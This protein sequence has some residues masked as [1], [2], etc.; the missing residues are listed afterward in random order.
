[1]FDFAKELR[2]ATDDSR[3]ETNKHKTYFK[4]KSFCLRIAKDIGMSVAAVNKVLLMGV[5]DAESVRDQ[6]SAFGYNLGMNGTT[7]HVNLT[8]TPPASSVLEFNGG[9]KKLFDKFYELYKEDPETRMMT[10]LSNGRLYILSE[11]D[12]GVGDSPISISIYYDEISFSF[13]E[14]NSL[15]ISRMIVEGR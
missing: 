3:K 6:M 11:N 1:M 8:A 2:N 5:Y 9:F 13:T 10:A 15:E 4:A 12:S 14:F 7:F